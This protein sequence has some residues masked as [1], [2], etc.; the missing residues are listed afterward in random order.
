LGILSSTR[1]RTNKLAVPGWHT[2]TGNNRPGDNMTGSE[3]HSNRISVSGRI[4]ELDGVRG[5]AI[6]MVL[7]WH[8]V[9]GGIPAGSAVEFAVVKQVLGSTW[10]GVDLFFVLSGFLIAGILIDNK[11]RD[12]YFKTFYI[13]RAC[14]IFPLYYLNLLLFTALSALALYQYAPLARLLQVTAVPEW[15]YWVFFQNVFM[16]EYNSFGPEWL[17][18]TWSLAVEEQFYLVLPLIV[19]IVPVPRLPYVFLGFIF[20]AV[21]LRATIP[22][23]GAY[24]NMPWRADSLMIGALLAYLVREPGFIKLVTGNKGRRRV[25]GVFGV[26]L[27]GALLANFSTQRPFNLTFTYIW[28]ACLYASLVLILLI[29]REGWLAGLFRNRVLMWLGGIS[30][31]V[32]LLHQIVSIFLHG[33][34]LGLAPVVT[35][36]QGALVTLLALGVTLLLAQ[37]SYV[38]IERRF[39][40]FGH[41][42]L[43]S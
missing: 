43:Y 12:N 8:Y 1:R 20:M 35:H 30:Y 32:Y 16:G 42:F 7:V 18:V 19:F 25:Y 4:R 31:A 22:G 27:A 5:F 23:F 36:W 9:Q 15:S 28:L 26:L 24:I 39:M 6:L 33:L 34:L 3:F 40:Q 14:R 11:G 21:L 10:S 38:I 2:R 29:N 17:S 41:R 37:L 13:R